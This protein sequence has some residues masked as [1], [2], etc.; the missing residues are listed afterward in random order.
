VAWVIWLLIA[1]AA[2]VGEVFTLG[3]YLAP[4][5]V[6]AVVVAVASPLLA[7]SA[8]VVIFLAI[9][10][11]LLVVAR[12]A[13]LRFLP[14]TVTEGP[15]IGPS[16]SIGIVVSDV[17]R[18][19]G[20]IRIGTGEFWSARLDAVSGLLLPGREV[21]IV[22]MKGL[23][24]IVRPTE[25]EPKLTGPAQEGTD[26]GLS[27]REIEV[28]QAM[29][30]GQSNAEIAAALVISPRTVDHHVSHILTKMN[31]GNRTEAVRLAL[32]GGIVRGS[33]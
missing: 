31:A 22:A 3:L 4:F 15:R 18:T 29:V 1:V 14:Q 27:R 10:L 28:L 16:A 23:T 30:L 11:V 19:N 8:Q 25:P 20:Q 33:S 5:A 13:V 24:A 2:A 21:E 12:P 9:A 6:A 7:Q 26:Y 17:S 32:E